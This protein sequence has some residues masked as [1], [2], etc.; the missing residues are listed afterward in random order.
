MRNFKTRFTPLSLLLVSIAF[1]SSIPLNADASQL[2]EGERYTLTIMHTNDIH[3][4]VDNLPKYSTIIK[5]TKKNTSLNILVLDGGDIF[6]RGEFQTLQGIP[7]IEMMNVMGYDALSCGNNDFRVP[8]AGGTPIDGNN[9][10][11]ALSET[12][13]F[14]I[15]SANV[16]MKDGSQ[17]SEFLKPYIVKEIRGVKVGIIGITSLKPQDRGWAEVS[18]KVFESGEI[19]LRNI[20]ETVRREADVVIVLSH[21]GLAV[22]LSMAGISG[23]SAVIGADDHLVMPKP[24]FYTNGNGEKGIPIVQNGGEIEHYL[25]RLDLTFQKTGSIMKLVD[26]DSRFYNNIES[27]KEDIDVRNIIDEYRKLEALKPAA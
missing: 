12:A 17:Y 10:L 11:K 21:A 13:K 5:D 6:L 15:L 20:I 22:D 8:P 7:E 2:N 26:Y 19:T 16:K 24:I 18:D 27:I 3:G 1:A 9:Q 4:R 14:P 25:R 23:I